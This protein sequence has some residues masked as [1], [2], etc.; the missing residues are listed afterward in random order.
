VSRTT[1]EAT[2]AAPA[3]APTTPS[4]CTPTTWPADRGARR[5][6]GALADARLVELECG[7]V[8]YAE[9]PAELAGLVA[10]FASAP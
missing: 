7:Q 10:E 5:R 9:R 2:P 3:A 6:A 8:T 4:S 1:A